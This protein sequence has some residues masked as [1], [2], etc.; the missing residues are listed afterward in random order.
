MRH[1]LLLG[2]LTLVLASC[3][4]SEEAKIKTE[5]AAANHCEV[6][7]DCELIGS[8]CPFDCYIYVHA[9]EAERMKT[10]LDGYQSTC[11][12]SCIASSGVECVDQKCQA[13]T[14][15][16][17]APE[18]NVGDACESDAGCDL[19]MDYATRSSCRFTAKC[20]AGSC[21]VICPMTEHD[22]Q[23]GVSVSHSVSCDKDADCECEGY[24]AR[25][26]TRCACLS[27]QCAA[28]V[29]Q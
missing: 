18:G 26:G 13:I 24:G 25:G 8:V 10:M 12:Y 5:L 17:P 6:A 15:P 27:G 19:P 1:Y 28:I 23:P 3:T 16:P 2:L 20:I 21:G 4:M 7:D 14:E 11:M 22:S 29:A 9:D